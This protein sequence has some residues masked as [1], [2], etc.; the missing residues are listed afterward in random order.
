VDIPGGDRTTYEY[1]LDNVSPSMGCDAQLKEALMLNDLHAR[2]AQNIAKEV[3][4]EFE[5]ELDKQQQRTFRLL[6]NCELVSAEDFDYDTLF[7]RYLVELPVGWTTVAESQMEGTTVTS[8]TTTNA[9][10][11]NSVAHFC[12]TFTVDLFF[13]INQLDREKDSMPKWPQ[14]FFEVTATDSWTRC[15]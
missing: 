8:K 1:W 14:I 4:D 13:D 15:R 11:G 10:T 7:V 5:P 2:H 12:H 6:L 3:S 9:K